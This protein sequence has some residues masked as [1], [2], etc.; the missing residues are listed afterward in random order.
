MI[1]ATASNLVHFRSM[2]QYYFQL[3]TNQ[4]A[5]VDSAPI[6]LPS[7]AAALVEAR[8]AARTLVTK[9]RRPAQ[10]LHGS[11]DVEDERRRPV[12]RILLAEIARQIS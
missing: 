12:A 6:E 10:P 5:P 1:A 2:P 3:R 8:S 11:L 7:L 4:S 9:A